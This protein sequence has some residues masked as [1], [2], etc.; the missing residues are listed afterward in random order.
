LRLWRDLEMDPGLR[1]DDIVAN[2]EFDTTFRLFC[3]VVT[4]RSPAFLMLR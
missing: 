4:V 3:V 2:A 1:R